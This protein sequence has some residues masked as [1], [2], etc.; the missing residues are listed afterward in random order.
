MATSKQ[1]FAAIA[2]AFVS[3][4]AL[5]SSYSVGAAISPD[6]PVPGPVLAV[7]NHP[8][9]DYA[10]WRVIYDKGQSA[11]DAMGVTGAEV[12][13][14]PANPSMVVEI[15]RFPS[16]EAA[17]QFLQHPA[18]KDAMTRAGVTAPPTIILAST[19]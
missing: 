5:V 2:I 3:V 12:F 15:H 6:Q 10:A 17:N 19:T 14:D 1:L 9:A 11:R 7:V 13:V 16:V 8:V 4:I 18:L